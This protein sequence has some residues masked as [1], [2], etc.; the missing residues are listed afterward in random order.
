MLS[1]QHGYHAGN[2]AD[3]LK[4]TVL[5]AILARMVAKEKPVRYIDTHAGSGSYDLKSPAAQQNREYADGIGRIWSATDAPPAVARLLELA[6]THNGT[7][8]LRRYPGSPWFARELL[9]PEDRLHLFELHPAEHR[10]LAREFGGARNVRV[11]REN[12]L[13][14]CIGLVPPPD[15][16]GLLLIDPSYE[17]GD[18]QREVIDAEIGRAH[19]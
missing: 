2:H 9:R 6:H 1:Y 17:R 3:V 15:R 14:G 13:V 11:L 16:R 18:E 10:R 19:V 12:G 5:T 4:H 7:G 8:A